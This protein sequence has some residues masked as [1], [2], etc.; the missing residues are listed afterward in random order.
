MTYTWDETKDD[1]TIARAAHMC[2]DESA[3]NDR[4]AS[5]LWDFKAGTATVIT[6]AFMA[7]H[8][9]GD[10]QEDNVATPEVHQREGDA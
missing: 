7:I 2:V 8:G 5:K 6:W 1:R 10:R 3:Q 4:R 9:G